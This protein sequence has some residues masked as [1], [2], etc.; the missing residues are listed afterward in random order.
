MDYSEFD[1]S[2]T[3]RLSGKNVEPE[4]TM[5]VTPHRT[6]CLI[7]KEPLTETL[8]EFEK[9]ES[10]LAD[11]D[12]SERMVQELCRFKG[13]C[14]QSSLSSMITHLLSNNVLRQ[15]C[16]KGSKGRNKRRIE[17]KPFKHTLTYSVIKG[18]LNLK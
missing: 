7:F 16:F 13:H 11:Y 12:Y 17:K 15:F 4:I 6:R 14:L 18:N 1:S 2:S 10:N 3:N 9:F 5:K 8:E